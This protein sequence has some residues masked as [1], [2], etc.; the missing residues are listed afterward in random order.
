MYGFLTAVLMQIYYS[1]GGEQD[2]PVISVLNHAKADHP[3]QGT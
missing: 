2:S 3:T 1:G